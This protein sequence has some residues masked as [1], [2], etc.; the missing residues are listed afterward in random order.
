MS[1]RMTICVVLLF[2]LL[3][4]SWA[5]DRVAARVLG[6]VAAGAVGPRG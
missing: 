5:L 6:W 2:A 4:L 3:L 1:M